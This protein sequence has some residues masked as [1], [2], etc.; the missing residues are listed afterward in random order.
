MRIFQIRTPLFNEA[1]EEGGGGG[2]SAED[3]SNEPHFFQ[4]FIGE[5]GSF[6]EGFT[7]KLPES[8][9]TRAQMLAD[10]GSLP[11][12]LERFA[13]S[14]TAARAKTEG[15]IKIPGEDA[16]D[17]DRAAFSEALG[18]PKD[19]EGYG[20]SVPEGLE[21]NY[22]TEA[23]GEFLGIA[24]KLNMTPEQAKAVVEFEAN[25]YSKHAETYEQAKAQ[26]QA[27]ARTELQKEFGPG[28]YDKKI[29]RAE[30]TAAQLGFD[31]KGRGLDPQLYTLFDK[32]RDSISPDRL[33]DGN[34]PATQT[35]LYEQAQSLISSADYGSN[36]GK[37][38]QASELLQRYHDLGGE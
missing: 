5:D 18:V 16:S 38:A 12:L 23:L 2:A 4:S 20:I 34:S 35:S 31:L 28:E 33:R 3:N 22:D 9:Q 25:R 30:D 8:L 19:V 36:P 14:Q 10:A 13:D 21:G 6:A 27:E 1:G 17:E 24:Q 15:M 7:E 37:Q 26:Q 29:T 32:L 11:N